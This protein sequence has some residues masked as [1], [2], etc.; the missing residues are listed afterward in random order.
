MLSRYIVVARED[1]R[2]RTTLRL[3]ELGVSSSSALLVSDLHCSEIPCKHADV[4]ARIM[5]HG[6]CDTLIVLGDLFERFHRRA[7]CKEVVVSVLRT[8]RPLLEG[9]R[10]IVYLTSWAS[11]DPLIESPCTYDVNGLTIAVSPYPLRDEIGGVEVYLTHGD[12]AVGSGALAYAINKF[13]C[14]LGEDLY[15]EKRLKNALGLPPHVWLVMGHTHIPGIDPKARVA[16]TGG[17][18]EK[19][20]GWIPYWKQPSYTYIYISEGKITL[21]WATL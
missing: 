3:A 5:K 4:L 7:S 9:A 1:A 11:H 10:N 13:M 18:K 8:L 14:A 21:R 16:N 12:L 20:W 2:A 6:A 19:V 17:W 15:I